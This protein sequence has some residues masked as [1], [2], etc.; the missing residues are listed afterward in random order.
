MAREPKKD[1]P[2][3]KDQAKI[4]AAT[5]MAELDAVCKGLK[6]GECD[7]MLVADKARELMAKEQFGL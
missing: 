6:D 4:K 3:F 2:K 7:G 1:T 5:T